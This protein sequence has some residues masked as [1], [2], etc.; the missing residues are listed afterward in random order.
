MAHTTLD[1]YHGLSLEEL[2]V[3]WVKVFNRSSPPF[4]RKDF[5]IGNLDYYQNTPMNQQLCRKTSKKLHRLYLE[6]QQNPNYQPDGSKSHLKPGTRL[7][8]EWKGDVYTVTVTQH[9]FEY[10]EKAYNSLSA[11]ARLIT[12][13]QCSGP[14]FFGITIGGGQ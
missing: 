9:G 1:A 2:K 7:V 13:T 3:L 5:L 11:I 10:Q 6:F 12:G 14:A 8:R 4:A